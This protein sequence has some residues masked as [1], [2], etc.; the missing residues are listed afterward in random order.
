MIPKQSECDAFYGNPRGNDGNASSSWESKNLIYI[1]SPYQLWM[2]DIKINRIKIHKK[3]A[4]SLIRVMSDIW[5]QCGKDYEK[6]KALNYH[7]FSGAYNYR[8]KRGHSS[9]S[10]HA[11]GCAIDFDAPHN[12]MGNHSPAF[13]A[14]SIIVKAFEKEGWTW[15][16]R[17]VNSTDGM[18]FQYADV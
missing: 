3:C 11:Y 15:G 16:G 8:L 7:V 13:H 2:G 1:V 4:D 12:Q 9:L 5:Q 18:H 6:I 14:D 17:W 10:M